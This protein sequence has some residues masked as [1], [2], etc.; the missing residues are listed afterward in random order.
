M[1]EID[2]IKLK[3]EYTMDYLDYLQNKTLA[4][5]AEMLAMGDIDCLQKYETIQKLQKENERL[6]KQI[7][8]LKGE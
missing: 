2:Y 1:K 5:M 8:K 7:K 6:K 4:E 3:H